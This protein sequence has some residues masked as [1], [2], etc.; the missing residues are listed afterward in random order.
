MVPQFALAALQ[1]VGVHDMPQRFGPSPPH[2]PPFGQVPQLMAPP[3]P[4]LTKPHDRPRQASSVVFGVQ[5]GRP[6][7]FA[8]PP[9]PQVSGA[10]QVP[11]V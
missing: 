6:H 3:Q 2:T 5:T 4:S 1:V 7:T 10:V 9:P 11:Q 8:R